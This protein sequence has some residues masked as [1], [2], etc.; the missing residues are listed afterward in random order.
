MK[1]ARKSK[2][3]N[4]KA[5]GPASQAL[6]RRNLSNVRVVQRNLVYVTNVPLSIAREDLL[7][8]LEYFGQYGRISKIVVNRANVHLNPSAPGGGTTSLYGISVLEM[9]FS[10]AYPQICDVR[11][12]GRC[13][14]RDPCS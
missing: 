12:R 3:K 5:Q 7:R 14:G 13:T 9:Q 1:E 8:R 4:K 11:A 6:A 2:D 10:H